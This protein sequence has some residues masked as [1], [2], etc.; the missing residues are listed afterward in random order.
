MTSTIDPRFLADTAPPFCSLEVAPSFALLT[1]KEQLYAH[2][3][4]QASWAG[5]RIIQGQW[6]SYAQ[7][8]YDLIILTFSVEKGKLADLAALKKQSGVSDEAWLYALEYSAQ[9]RRLN[10][11]AALYRTD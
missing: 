3:V 4:S 7:S 6:T 1:D 2:Y 8:L 10:L 11:L 9:V 5:A